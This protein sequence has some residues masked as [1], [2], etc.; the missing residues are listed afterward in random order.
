MTDIEKRFTDEA[1]RIIAR[2][3][4]DAGGNE[5]FATGVL[6]ESGAVAEV[7]VNARGHDGA[8]LAIRDADQ[9]A[10]VL[11][12]NHPSGGLHPS[13]ADLSIAARA[14]ESGMGFYIVDNAVG[15]VYAV[16]EPVLRKSEE[17]VDEEAV[18][19]ILADGGALSA[20][21]DF[22]EERPSQI[23]LARA[24][25]RSFN[26]GL[27]GA[28]EAG[29]GVGKSFAYL[30]P[31]MLWA[32]QNK[33][34]VVVS[35]GTIN[36][37]QQLM[38]KDIP[39][40]SSLVGVPIKAVL[41][42]GRQNYV[43]L[44]RLAEAQAERE[45]FDDEA[46]ELARIA[47]WAG[48]TPDGSRSD[49][50]FV[51][52][53][54]VWSRVSSES[55]ACMGMRCGHREECFVMRVRKE[56]ASASLLVVNHHLLFADLQARMMGAGY[57]DTAVLPPFRHIVFD[58]AH[59]ME[60]A[61]TSFFSEYFTRFKLNKQISILHR[62]RRG[63]VAGHLIALERLSSAAGEVQ[64]ATAAI[65]AAKDAFADLE[66]TA[67]GL[68][69]E[70]GTW[71]LSD[72][73]VGEAATL[74]E[75]L[76]RVRREIAALVGV[77][78]SVIDGIPEEDQNEGPVWESKFALRRLEFVGTIAL[79]FCEWDERRESVYWIER[80][81]LTRSSRGDGAS[82]YPRF[83]ETPLSI[84][85][86][87]REAVFEPFRTVVCASATLRVGGRFD[88]WIRRSGVSLME[89]ERV[90]TG[91]YDS[92][93]P[94]KRNVLFAVPVDAPLPDEPGFQ[95]WVE[96]AVVSLVQASA[97]RALVLFTSY[98]SLRSACD[99]ARAVL[100][101]LG[102]TVLRQG[103]DDRSRLLESFKRDET[104][105]LFATDSFW[106]GV[107][108]PGDTLLHVIMVKLPFRVPNDPV[109][110]ARSESIE[111]AGGNAFMELSLPE[112]VM[113][114]RQG[115]GRLMRRKTDRGVVTVLDRRLVAKRYGQIFV[116]SVPETA[117]AFEPLSDIVSRVER[118]LFP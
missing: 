43:C 94:Y 72:R 53:E 111:G 50:S 21:S 15:E 32:A 31:S 59:A 93:F 51:P 67:L 112:A 2:A 40:A 92:P 36:L 49:L 115:F 69:A 87:M 76:Q 102:I 44:R 54:A 60:D 107:D 99:L 62:V 23:D 5:V 41:L 82:W 103:D 10:E 113:R 100:S 109:H 29:T 17:P 65:Q 85:P 19:G 35:T 63:S 4:A 7:R 68:V 26:G 104:S 6:D 14:A 74:F 78:R 89:E 9:E 114:F 71:R 33:D 55:D 34:R 45:L 77:L 39:L 86:M 37:Q 27:I 81:K 80:V 75:R 84:A 106:E 91:V 18:A 11:I 38:E 95:S 1:R 56:A 83:V 13:E 73:T 118:F 47:E 20:A 48:T 30:L 96:T 42:K 61:A 108:A 105:V 8:V 64:A 110:A 28:F 12:H 57:E 70:A 46:E 22:Y 97:G 98:E 52:K 3:I 79:H 90:V 116:D 101:P 117:R 58:E 25:T 24:V 66:D 88:Y 16:V